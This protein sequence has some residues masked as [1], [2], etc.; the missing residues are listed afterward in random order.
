VLVRRGWDVTLLHFHYGCRAWRQEA[1]AVRAVARRLGCAVRYVPLGWLGQLGASP[2]TAGGEIARA[3][4]GAESP[5]EWVPARNMLMI[6]SACALADADG[7][8]DIALG[9][10]LEEAG[11][12]PDNTQGFVEVMDAASQLGTLQRP[13]I[14]AP[15]GNLVKHQIV[16]LGVEVDAPMDCTWSCYSQGPL[17]CGACGPCFMRRVAFEMHDLVDPVPFAAPLERLRPV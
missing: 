14:T 15:V 16:A 7:Y 5:Q 17:H 12:Y 2:L 3:E 13:C 11:A 6:A 10:N 1:Q 8:T 9:T 4:L